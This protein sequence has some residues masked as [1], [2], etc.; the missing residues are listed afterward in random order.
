M[1]YPITDLLQRTLQFQ[2]D[3]TVEQRLEKREQALR[4]YSLPLEESVAL[5]APLVSV[6]LPED[7]YPVS[8]PGIIDLI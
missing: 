8:R 3:D 4:P 6:S 2:P 1:W 5:F 7:R